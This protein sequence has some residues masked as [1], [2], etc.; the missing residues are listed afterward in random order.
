MKFLTFLNSGCLEICLNML[1]SAENVGID[2]DDFIIA[3]MDEA[4][5]KSLLYRGYKGSFLYMDQDLKEYQDWTF[6]Q[7]S[8]FRNIVRHKWKIINDIPVSYTHLTLPT[9]REV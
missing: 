8:G 4:V 9:N 5:Y 6:D 1:K 3:C 2:K 7:N